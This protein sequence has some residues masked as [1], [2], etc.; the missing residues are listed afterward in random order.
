MNSKN[1]GNKTTIK[2]IKQSYIKDGNSNTLKRSDK[3]KL[4]PTYS[5]IERTIEKIPQYSYRPNNEIKNILFK[6]KKQNELH[7]K[8]HKKKESTINPALIRKYSY[9]KININPNFEEKKGIEQHKLRMT[10]SKIDLNRGFKIQNTTFGYE[11]KVNELNQI[12]N[13]LKYYIQELQLQYNKKIKDIYYEKYDL[14]KRLKTEKQYLIKENKELKFKIL[15][16][17]YVVKDYEKNEI[18][19]NNIREK[20]YSQIIQENKYLRKSNCITDNINNSIYR[21]LISDSLL[22]KEKK[23][24]DNLQEKSLNINKIN[25]PFII[26]DFESE[27]DKYLNLHKRQITYY[28]FNNNNNNETNPSDEN[29]E[30]FENKSISSISSLKT[31]VSFSKDYNQDLLDDTL[32]E[33]TLNNKIMKRNNNSKRN[34]LESEKNKNENNILNSPQTSSKKKQQQLYYITSKEEK[35]KI[36]FTK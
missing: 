25:N 18:K 28:N 12:I 15:E 8:I 30:I 32:K 24:T 27:N 5:N 14:I 10:W 3:R 21:K 9:S 22:L 16:L 19:L 13:I 36:L 11:N 1:K 31:I 33:M 7:H 6:N 29:Y 26:D 34:I 17:F 35:N 23:L 2:K 4:T 20:L